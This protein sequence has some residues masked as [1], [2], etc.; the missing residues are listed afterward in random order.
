MAFN[1]IGIGQLRHTVAL[2]GAGVPVAD[3][4]GGYTL[5]YVPLSPAEWKCSIESASASDMER[6]L[7]QGA[8]MVTAS[9]IVRGRYHAGITT[10]TRLRLE[11]EDRTLAVQSVRDEDGRRRRLVLM[12]TEAAA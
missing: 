5:A 6:A 4:T 12:C 10:G 8:V 11:L 9:F 3:G 1:R 2:E 7:G